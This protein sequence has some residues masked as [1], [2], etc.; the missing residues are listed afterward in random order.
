[1]GL[2]EHL[3]L[4]Q[5]IVL[6]VEKCLRCTIF[7]IQINIVVTKST[8]AIWKVTSVYFRQLM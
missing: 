3:V 4:L 1:M 5:S 2:V 7:K 6:N 8:R